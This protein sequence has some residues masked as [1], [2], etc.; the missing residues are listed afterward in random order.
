[1]ADLG[2]RLLAARKAANLTQQ[3]LA[4]RARTT[5]SVICALEKG[6]K[7]GLSVDLLE[8]I[9]GAVG[10]APGALLDAEAA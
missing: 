1:M 2:P 7:R 5:T 6:R 10:V 3:A 4:E 8:R 9:A